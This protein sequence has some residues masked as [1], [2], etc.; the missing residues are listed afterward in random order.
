M[1]LASRR[2]FYAN[3]DPDDPIDAADDRFVNL[4]ELRDDTVTT[5]GQLEFPR[6][7]N[8]VDRLENQVLLS[9]DKPICKYFTGLRGSGKSTVLRHLAARLKNETRLLAVTVDAER[10]LDLRAEIDIPDIMAALVYETEKSILKAEDKNTEDALQEGFGSRLWSWWRRTNVDLK[11]VNLEMENF[12]KGSLVLEMKT[13]PTLRQ[14]LRDI[15][16]LHFSSFIGEVRDELNNLNE[17]AKKAGFSGLILILDSLEKLQGISSTWEAVLNSAER[18]FSNGA[19][20]LQL[21]VHII[22][23]IPPALALRLRMDVHYLPM[24]KLQSKTGER[25]AP[26]FSAA[27]RLIDLRIPKTFLKSILGENAF[28]ERVEQLIR[29]S[30]GYPREI[31]RLLRDLLEMADDDNIPLS[32]TRFE[33]VLGHAGEE[34][35]R[36]VRGSG[37]FGWLASV[38]VDQAISLRKPEDHLAADKMLSNN[39]ILRYRNREEWFD[40]HPAVRAM[41]EIEK[42]IQQLKAARENAAKRSAG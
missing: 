1:D 16:G 18:I 11:T 17:R 2:K 6:G 42:A 8:W 15:I 4:D 31:I 35:R 23:T 28:A 34:Y 38:A 41:P 37:A 3:C 32:D 19:P 27:E 26:G 24:I 22:Y 13:R 12:L 14:Q 40:L 10:V 33:D 39:V 29:W 30:G 20:Y 9:A 36:V 21:P 5:A 7:E 25:Y